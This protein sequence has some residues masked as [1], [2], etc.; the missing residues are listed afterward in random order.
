MI[1]LT[2]KEVCAEFLRNKVRI[3]LMVLSIAGGAFAITS[4]LALGEGLRL[5]FAAKISGANKNILIV[6]GGRATHQHKNIHPNTPINL[7]KNDF[8]V[9]SNLPNINKISAE[10][11]FDAN[12][13][14]NEKGANYFVQAVSP[15]Y[16]DINR[17]QIETGGRLI[18]GDDIK[19]RTKVIILGS[20]AWQELFEEDEN[21]IGQQVFVGNQ[22]FLVIGVM[23]AQASFIASE[24]PE[25][26]SN[27]IPS[28]TYELLA[29]PQIIDSISMSYKD[30]NNLEYTKKTIR[31]LIS[32][33]HGAS[34][35]DPGVVNFYD[36]TKI[37]RTINMFFVGM[38]IFL[39]MIGVFTLLIGGV[40]IANVMYAS[41]VG[42]THS[43]GIRMALGARTQNILFR[44]I[45]ESVCA[46]L[47]GGLI[48]LILSGL[49]VY[50]V[51]KI[52]ITGRLLEIVGKP[53]PKLSFLVVIMV[54]L[55]LTITGFLA[56]IF[57]ALKAA[58]IDPA[59]ALSYE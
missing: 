46:A 5:G 19:R 59:D 15:D 33:N 27:F 40:G 57:P 14:H 41:I 16:F 21:P 53:Y 44:Y 45:S 11:E 31:T 25:E 38:Q 24:R 54:V 9:I 28:S 26:F 20:D 56:G 1:I 12:V 6:E 7:T 47:I 32:L 42:D 22:T 49:L 51:S 8:R 50:G 4:M 43:I 37:Q 13:Y 36:A 58:S 18:N 55:V 39:G 3:I 10:Y 29:N 23:R 17:F 48:G 35:N 2:S 34:P 52:P 30:L